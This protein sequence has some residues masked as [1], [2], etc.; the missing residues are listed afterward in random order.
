MCIALPECFCFIKLTYLL[1]V[2]RANDIGLTSTVRRKCIVFAAV[3][4]HRTSIKIDTHY[5]REH[6]C[7]F[8]T[9][10][11]FLTPEFVRVG[12]Q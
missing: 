10:V 9:C 8:L 5:S 7:Y 6:E 2:V 3:Y 1:N 4:I 11:S 12:P